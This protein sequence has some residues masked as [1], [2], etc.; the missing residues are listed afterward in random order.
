MDKHQII[1]PA[2]HFKKYTQSDSIIEEYVNDALRVIN[3]DIQNAF[4]NEKTSAI[5]EIST[6]FDVPGLTHARAQRYVY[7][8]IL[9]AL[10]QAHYIPRIEIQE[11]RVFMHITWITKEDRSAE[12]YM[13]KFIMDHQI[14]KQVPIDMRERPKP[15]TRKRKKLPL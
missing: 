10:E 7:F 3:E 2:Y 8:H 1:I 9:Q 11:K 12:L 15:A 14:N 6:M 13:D 5:T 4:D